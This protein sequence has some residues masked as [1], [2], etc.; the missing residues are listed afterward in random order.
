M[1]SPGIKW[2]HTSGASQSDLPLNEKPPKI[3]PRFQEI[4]PIERPLPSQILTFQ[5]GLA[6]AALELPEPE[7]VQAL[8]EALE[9][10]GIFRRFHEL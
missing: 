4:P 6:R 1:A 2:V 3:S 7:R 5:R 8:R 9:V 10:M